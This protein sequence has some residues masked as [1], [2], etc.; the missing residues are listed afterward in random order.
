MRAGFRRKAGSAN[1]GG[2]DEVERHRARNVAHGDKAEEGPCEAGPCRWKASRVAVV[3]WASR[4]RVAKR[5]KRAERLAAET[6][7]AR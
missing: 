2:K 3:I 1:A 6:S 7:E 4:A 5:S